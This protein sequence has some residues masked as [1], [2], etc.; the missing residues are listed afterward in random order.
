MNCVQNRYIPINKIV[1]DFAHVATLP[2]QEFLHV[3]N[4]KYAGTRDNDAV[5]LH[6]NLP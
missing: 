4:V 5:G 6:S 2:I 1:T 3:V